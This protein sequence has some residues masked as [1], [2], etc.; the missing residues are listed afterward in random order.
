MPSASG[1]VRVGII[2]VGGI[3]RGAH[4]PGYKQLHDVDLVA[5]CDI[6]PERARQ[7]VEEFGAP[8]AKAYEDYHDLLARDDID[9]VSVCTPN[10]A[11]AQIT[12][13]ALNAGKDVICEKPMATS[14]ADAWA[15]VRAAQA[16]QRILTVGYQHRFSDD[17]ALLKEMV[18]DGT[19]GEVYYA[20]AIALR[21]RGVPTWGVFLDKEKQ[22]GGPL[23]DIGTHTVDRTLWL[24][25][26]I[27]KPTWVL[28]QTFRKLA[29]HPGYNLW[30]RWD[31]AKFQV[32]DAGFGFVRFESGAVLSVETS[33]ALNIKEDLFGTVLAGSKAG[34]EL[35]D[36]LRVYS[37]ERGR[38]VDKSFNPGRSE[39][40]YHREI[41]HFIDRVKSRKAPLV[42]PEEAAT[43]VEVLD[44][45]YQSAASGRPETVKTVQ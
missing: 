41:A 8:G 22:G 11:H 36:G 20:R 18:D 25:G 1:R 33:W 10:A 3:A 7:G 4:I 40:L 19:V 27:G 14:P 21:R 6:I 12:I 5:F 32:E 45:I 17:A 30:G 13:A 34:A 28:A 38:L 9:A 26:D 35:F 29:D 39:S 37:E 23:I 15:M 2:G 31:P 44:A 43:V 24:M 16:N 42:K